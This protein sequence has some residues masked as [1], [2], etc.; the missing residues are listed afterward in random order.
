[1][2]KFLAFATDKMRVVVFNVI[3]SAMLANVDA[4]TPVMGW[5]TWTTFKCNISETLI[6]SSIKAL[7]GNGFVRAGY[8]TVLID[9]CWSAP[10]NASGAIQ[11]D[12]SRFPRGFAPLITFA[13]NF[14][15]RM[16]IYTSVGETTCAG[17]T[18]S[19][20]FEEQDAATF[21]AWGFD[22]VKHDTCVDMNCTV[23]NGCIQNA[24]RRMRDALYRVSDGQMTYYLDAG[25]PSNEMKL[26]NP[27]GHGVQSMDGS[28]ATSAEQLAWRW[29]TE[30]D[31]P[32]EVKGQS[33]GPHMIKAMWDIK[34]T[35]LNTLMNVHALI[36]VA[37]Y[38]ACDH[39]ITPD[40]L[41]VGMGAQTL[42]QYRAQ[43][44]LWAVLGAPLILSNDIRTID[45][46]ALALVTNP[47]VI[48][49]DQDADCVMGSLVSAK[50]SGE[51]WIRPLADGS[52]A[53]VLLN[54]DQSRAQNITL[55]IAKSAGQWG[56]FFPV[57]FSDTQQ[58]LIRDVGARID[59]GNFNYTFTATV[60]P[61]DAVM[62]RVTTLH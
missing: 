46:D 58:L 42:A 17:F 11:V 12:H 23:R 25:N 1:M 47:E 26:Y 14:G 53:V 9:D 60:G 52:F 7:A 34:D 21:H 56:D 22:F 38:H 32:A 13:R 37:P 59:L 6:M 10:R 3:A 36:R 54:K 20:G 44:F 48:D 62:L 41:T 39:A 43:F 61:T 15:I 4:R 30:L 5:S 45:S 40:M 2:A 50:G 19:L 29:A 24:T 8:D 35:W 55:F 28:I 33:R 16:G 18:G 51:T 27:K 57:V 49:I 31:D